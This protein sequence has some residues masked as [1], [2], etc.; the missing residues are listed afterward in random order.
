M[1]SNTATRLGL[2]NKPTEKHLANMELLAEKIFEPLRKHV[3]GPIKINSFY[4]GPELNQAIGGS[5][6][7]Q[8]CHG[9]AMDIDYTYGYMA[10]VEM[11][12]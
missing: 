5:S 9:Q 12:K 11:Y 1:Y 4:R 6:K 10:N 8:H 2:E 3:N 7:S